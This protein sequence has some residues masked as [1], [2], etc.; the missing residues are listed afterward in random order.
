MKKHYFDQSIIEKLNYY[1]YF[2][3]DPKNSEIFYIWKWYWNRVF[4]H[5]ENALEQ[6]E[7]CPKLDRKC[8]KLDRIRT[9]IKNW[10]KVGYSI[11][12]HWLTQDTA[13]EI[14]ATL[15]DIFRWKQVLKS[16]ISNKVQGF[17]TSRKWIMNMNEIKQFYW[18]KKISITDPI[19]LININKLY[20]R[21]IDETSLYNAV[22]QS[23]KV[24]IRREKA[25]Y[26]LWHYKWI[27][28]E[29]YEIKDR[30]PIVHKWNER[31]WFKWTLAKE[32]IREK[33]INWIISEYI[34][35]WSANPIRY[36]NC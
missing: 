18:W 32:E 5:A 34:I 10:R 21:N 19:I 20:K 26:A 12:R 7:K 13:H 6:S 16:D 3:E 4:Q 1:V 25:K 9:I 36:V 17:H 24:W 11:V 8:H 22:R 28:R 14:E 15:I 23:R 27:V 29:V 2:L 30:F 35:K 31:W 33:Y